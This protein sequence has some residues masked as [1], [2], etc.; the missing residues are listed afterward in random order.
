MSKSF[1]ICGHVSPRCSHRLGSERAGEG[2]HR[3][4]DAGLHSP[5]MGLKTCIGLERWVA[6]G[7]A[8]AAILGRQ[9]TGHYS[10]LTAILGLTSTGRCFGSDIGSSEYETLLASGWRYWV[11]RVRD[12]ARWWERYRACEYGTLLRWRYRVAGYG[13]VPTTGWRYWVDRV[14]DAFREWVMILGLS[15]TGRCFGGDIGSLEYGTLPALDGDTGSFEYGTLLLRRY[16]V[17]RVRDAVW[18]V[19]PPL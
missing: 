3:V 8:S 5:D 7:A 10:S 2:E 9:S 1:S 19:G 13:T 17:V 18:E 12:A 14:R 15:S 6:G 4:E 16:R 11:C